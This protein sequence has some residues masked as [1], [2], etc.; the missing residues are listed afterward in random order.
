M[1]ALS[2]IRKTSNVCVHTEDVYVVSR[3]RKL[4]E[5]A[6]A[7][8]EDARGTRIG[9]AE[10]WKRIWELIEEHRL[11]LTA[12]AG[13]HSYSNWLQEAMKKRKEKM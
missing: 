4:P 13:K 11:T 3:I 12:K 10:L 6:A 8:W 9:N 2:R 5:M 7:N 1:A